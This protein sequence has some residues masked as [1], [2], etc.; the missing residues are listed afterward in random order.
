LGCF[1]GTEKA[2]IAAVS[3]KYGAKSAYVSIVKAACA[4]VKEGLK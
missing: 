1:W 4:V 3:K 2:A